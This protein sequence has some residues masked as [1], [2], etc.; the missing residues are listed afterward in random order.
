ME[1]LYADL[2]LGT[3]GDINIRYGS[4]LK[5]CAISFRKQVYATVLIE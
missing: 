3:S 5:E 2:H 4:V 1:T